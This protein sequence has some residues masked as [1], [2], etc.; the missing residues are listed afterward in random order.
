MTNS[1]SPSTN[2]YLTAASMLEVIISDIDFIDSTFK[3][4]RAMLFDN[5]DKVTVSNIFFNRVTLTLNEAITISA[6]DDFTMSDSQI[7][8]LDQ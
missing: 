2:Y 8:A 5:I 1:P 4:G 3:A 6:V 7:V